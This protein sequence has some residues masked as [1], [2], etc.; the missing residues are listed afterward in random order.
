M[1][2]GQDPAQSS[3]C[4]VFI[5]AATFF[6]VALSAGDL[7]LSGNICTS[8]SSLRR[9]DHLLVLVSLDDRWAAQQCSMRDVTIYQA[10]QVQ[11]ALRMYVCTL[12]CPVMGTPYRYLQEMASRCLRGSDFKKGISCSTMIWVSSPSLMSLGRP[13]WPVLVIFRPLIRV[14]GRGN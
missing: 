11:A 12:S 3:S 10:Q 4:L 7:V 13:T 14:A 8:S 2:P 1:E 6:R 5:P 9:T